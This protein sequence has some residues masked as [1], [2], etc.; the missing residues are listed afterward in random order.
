MKFNNMIRMNKYVTDAISEGVTSIVFTFEG[1]KW[2][3][4]SGAVI[5]LETI[6]NLNQE[7]VDVSFLSIEGISHKSAISY[8]KAMGIFQELGLTNGPSRK[9][10][11]TY[12]AP[13]KVNISEVYEDLADSKISLETYH[14]GLAAKIIRKI[15]NFTSETD[16]S[17]KE[18]L[19]LYV[20]N[21][22]IR[23]IFDHSKTE[24][25][26]Y[27]SQYI[28]YTS[29]VEMVISDR[30]VGLKETIP[31]DEEEKW[32][33]RDTSNAAIYKAITPGLT[34]GSNHGSVPQG[35][36]NSGYGLA[37][38]KNIITSAKG[39]LSIASGDSSICFGEDEDQLEPCSIQGTVVRLR[40]DLG[41]LEQV[42][43]E[44]QLDKA[45]SEAE[46]LGYNNNPSRKSQT[47]SMVRSSK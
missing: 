13:R 9:E 22:I 20:V 23:N 28:N 30:G 47:M 24:Y 8:G 27:A 18:R 17:E 44:E 35:Y 26:Y 33:E 4:P 29:I 11:P 3:D 14:D 12:L 10:G 7:D 34:A 2:I 40:L 38:V 5:L 6:E 46:S 37:I 32:F 31:F 43:F 42:S 1:L 16:E 39:T 15:F 45:R 36:E 41:N 21:E 19:F 25:F